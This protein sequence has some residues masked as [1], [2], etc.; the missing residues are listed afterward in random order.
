MRKHQGDVFLSPGPQA[1]TDERDHLE[2]KVSFVS[3]KEKKMTFD[4]GTCQEKG[5]SK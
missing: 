5:T 4:L 2:I 3:K 1:R